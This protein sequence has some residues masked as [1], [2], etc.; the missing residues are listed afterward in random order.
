MQSAMLTDTARNLKG[1]LPNAG[2]FDPTTP[3]ALYTAAAVSIP[4]IVPWTVTQMVPTN[5]RLMLK[6]AQNDAFGLEEAQALVAKWVA[7][8]MVRVGLVVFGTV[9]GACGAVLS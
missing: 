6:A 1:L 9:C 2:P 7:L 5:D 8:H 3:F 4:A